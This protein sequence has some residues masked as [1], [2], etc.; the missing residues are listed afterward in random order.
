MNVR[1]LLREPLFHFLLIGALLFGIGAIKGDSA[2]VEPMRRIVIDSGQVISLIEGW[3]R[4]WQRPPT[5][6]E[7]RGL[8]DDF[9]KEEIFYREAMALGLDR[10]DAI[11]RRRLRQKIEFLSDDVS[12]AIDPTDEELQTFLEENGAS[13]RLDATF[14]LAH[15]YFNVDRRGDQAFD[16]AQQSIG[17]LHGVDGGDEALLLGD[18]LPLPMFFADASERDLSTA[19]GPLFVEGVNEADVG[20]WHG[21]IRSGFGFHVVY[22]AERTE[23]RLPALDEVRLAVERDWR[24]AKRN[25]VN[26][27]LFQGLRDQYLISVQWPDALKGMENR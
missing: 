11:I 3:R 10:D 27:Q 17:Q 19:F 12:E 13:Y 15:R 14:T 4:T 9:L 18:P 2:S 7:L 5:E 25:E 26:A 16:Q 8:V 1:S 24:F 20:S 22:V 21:P 6:Q 23:G